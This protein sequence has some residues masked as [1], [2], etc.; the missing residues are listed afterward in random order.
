M[1]SRSLT[2]VY[3]LMRNNA[4]QNRNIYS[5]VSCNDRIAL[6]PNGDDMEMG[7]VP[8]SWSSIVEDCQYILV[9]LKIKL[10]SL[11]ELHSKAISRP[12]FNDSSQDEL[13][14]QNLSEDITRMY[15][16]LY[17]SIGQIYNEAS[18]TNSHL[19]KKLVSS[20]S[21]ALVAEIQ[22]LHHEFRTM[23]TNYK[24]KLKTR[25][26]R[27]K[28]YFDAQLFDEVKYEDD[29]DSGVDWSGQTSL[30]IAEERI[31]EAMSRERDVDVIVSSVI[32]L[33]DIY[34][35]LQSLV[36]HQGTVLDR[37]DYQI[38]TTQCQVKQATT[39]LEKAAK[40][41]RGNKKMVCIMILVVTIIL[42][43]FLLMLIKM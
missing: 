13:Q 32:G 37:I 19:E 14:I 1:A 4:S 15:N 21:R 29:D 33:R 16:G 20:V 31:Q 30:Q 12:T 6:V 25:E 41:Q 11:S 38:E 8:P 7:C 2:E 24:N 42:L 43:I 17:R 10:A 36:V 22:S 18:H 27:S 26:D 35:E 40:Y 9:R 5:D 3:I 28:A 23:E 39:Q 34:R